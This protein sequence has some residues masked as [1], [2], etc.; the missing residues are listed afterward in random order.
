M[1]NE[2]TRTPVFRLCFPQ[3]FTP[4][5][6][7]ESGKELYSCMAVFPK[8]TDLSALKQI[9][10]AAFKKRFPNGAR[11]SRNPFRDGNEMVDE[12][13]DLFKDTVFIR[14]SSQYK[15]VVVDGNRIA[16]T[17]QS[18]VYSGCYARAAV[19]AY[20]Y[21]VKGNRGVSF[22]FDA[23][24][25]TRDGDPLSGG[26]AAVKLFDDGMDCDF[27]ATAKSAASSPASAP[28]SND[29]SGSGLFD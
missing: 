10:E 6:F 11:A 16:I 25:I 29:N 21:D 4:K 5:K 17:N 23:I 1:K 12:W 19:H 2:S 14:L 8:S 9:A 3:L 28:A 13:G 27:D 20:A 18:L 7:E 26:A 15:P 22:G 24:Q